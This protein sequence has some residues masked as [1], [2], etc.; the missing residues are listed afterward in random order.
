M[1][2][3]LEGF[4]GCQMGISHK[5]GLDLYP[6]LLISIRK[7]CSIITKD[8]IS[9]KITRDQTCMSVYKFIPYLHCLSLL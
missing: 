1:G 3:L 5:E 8:A 9:L 6:L 4:V 2:M 7:S